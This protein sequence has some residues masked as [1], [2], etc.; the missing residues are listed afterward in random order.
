VVLLPLPRA[1]LSDGDPAGIVDADE[2]QVEIERQPCP[3][4]HRVQTA[5]GLAAAPD[6]RVAVADQNGWDVLASAI[7]N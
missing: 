4:G 7:A 2:D 1:S 3:I 6:E 5:V